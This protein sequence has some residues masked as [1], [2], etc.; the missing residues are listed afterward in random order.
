MNS[1]PA[2]SQTYKLYDERLQQLYQRSKVLPPVNEFDV[3]DIRRVGNIS[4]TDTRFGPVW[5]GKTSAG[6]IV[7]VKLCSAFNATDKSRQVSYLN[8]FMYSILIRNFA[9]VIQCCTALES[10]ASSKSAK[11]FGSLVSSKRPGRCVQ[12]C[13]Q[14]H[15]KRRCDTVHQLK[16]IDRPNTFGTLL[17]ITRQILYLTEDERCSCLESPS[18]LS[19]YMRKAFLMGNVV[20]CAFTRLC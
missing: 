20:L 9:D 3:N 1:Y 10:S 2:K 18:V 17:R 13:V 14:G 16:P 12:H 4:T 6:D 5:K 7:S 15:Q 19:I 8:T 11:N